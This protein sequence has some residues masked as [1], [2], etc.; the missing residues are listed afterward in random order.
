MRCII[1]IVLLAIAASAAET[2]DPSVRPMRAVIDRYAED[3]ESLERRYSLR[4]AESRNERLSRF[5]EEQLEKL[6]QLKFSDLDVAGRIDYA[7]LKTKCETELKE[8]AHR[9]KQFEEASALVPFA[10]TVFQLEES[11]RK[12]ERSDGEAAAK[13]LAEI[14]AQIKTLKN[15]NNQPARGDARPTDSCEGGRG[16]RD[17]IVANRAAQKV[18][19]LR[20]ILQK[21]HDFYAGYDPVFTWWVR[22]PYEKLDKDLEDYGKFIKKKLAGYESD[23]D[24]PVIGDPIGREALL[25][26]LASEFIPYTPEELIEIANTEF[27]WCEKEMKRAADDLG[28]SG[29]W[30]KALD[31]VSKRHVPPGEQPKLIRELAEEATQFVETSNLVTVPPLCKEIWRI[32][33]MSIERQKVTPYFTGGEVISISYPT[34]TM[35]HED[36]LMSMRGNNPSFSRATVHHELIP[37]HHLQGFMSQRYNTHRRPFHTPFLVEGWALY[38]EMLLWDMNFP[39]NAEDR[40]GM[41]FWRSHRCA[42]IIFSL[43][44]HLGEMTAQEAIDFLVDRVGHERRNATAEVRRS[45][46]GSYSPQYQAAYMLG[47]LQIRAM[48]RELVQSGKMTAREFHDSVLRENAIPIELIRASLRKEK[49]DRDFKSK[50]RFYDNGAAPKVSAS[51][52]TAKLYRE[53]VTPHW[54]ANDEQFWYRINQPEGGTEFIVVDASTGA[55]QPAFD[56]AR[57]SRKIEDIKSIEFSEDGK[58]LWLYEDNETWECALDTYGLHQSDRKAKEAPSRNRNRSRPSNASTKSPDGKWEVSV[59]D[60]NLYLNDEPLTTNATAS[61]SYARDVQRDRAVDME[62]DTPEPEK[63]TPRVIWAPDSKRFVAFRHKPGTK[64]LVYMVESSP[65]DQ[66]QPRLQ[67]YAYLKPGDDVPIQKPHLFDVES[68]T[69]IA[70]DDALFSNPWSISDLRWSSNST[71]FTFLYNQ[72]GHQALRVIAVDAKH[73]T[74]RPI[75]DEKSDTFIDYSGKIF[76]EYVDDTSEIIWASERDGWNHLYLYDAAKGEVKNQITKGNWLVRGVDRVDHDKRQIW[77]RAGGIR[78]EQ[79]PYF[80]HYCRVNFDG[81]G[82]AILTQGNGTHTAQFSGDR[83]F[84]VDTWSRVDYPP[85]HELRR[86]SDGGLI[87]KLEQAA[88]TGIPMPEPF[89]AK[90]RD[91]TTDIYGVIHRPRDFDGSK[92]YPVIESIYA[93]PH[94]AFVP[95]SFRAS[96]GPQ[97]LADQG[98]IVVQIDGMG[99]S[100]RSKK[101]HDVCWKNLGDAGFPD[102]ILWMKAAA[103]KYPY[104]DLSR[105]GIYGGSA[106]GQNALRGLLA[107][108]D[109]YKVGGADCGC[110]DNRMDKIWWNEQWMGWPVGPQYEEQSNVTQAKNLQGKL[111]L[112]VGELDRNVDPSSTMQVVNALIKADKDFELIVFPGAGHGAGGSPYGERRLTEFFKRHLLGVEENELSSPHGARLS[113]LSTQE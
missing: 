4:D 50:W 92:L 46:N 15:T 48:H 63:P 62:Y 61:D 32:E 34:D 91:S 104:M 103:K 67:S 10:A 80:V 93:G 23:D 106:G 83:R 43:K 24:E 89:V 66:V 31:F 73:G 51:K 12:M 53:T 100:Q 55:K 88:A 44:F 38:W 5:Q 27:A 74:A 13:A 25:D 69:E 33:M 20:R 29:D 45:V 85:V 57:L 2:L 98:F 70:I 14:S 109:F 95:K 7:L 1:P 39:R 81:G 35:S 52:T 28:F 107:H 101:F 65:K 47:G 18:D 84:F 9:R 112:A 87:C 111:L 72:R 59:R 54:F 8:L 110:H 68:K 26:A 42:R 6:R 11:R 41:L 82:L 21:W 30:K 3:L 17:K 22:Q 86:G 36:K 77:F 58:L 64:R 78:P 99:T 49:L 97:K 16:P 40:V 76:C 60:N 71:R 79:D 105:V 90:G 56:H 94:G 113:L 108:G 102:R 19:E 37:G 75:I 96:H